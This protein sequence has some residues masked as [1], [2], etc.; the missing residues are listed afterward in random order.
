VNIKDPV[1]NDVTENVID[2]DGSISCLLPYILWSPGATAIALDGL[3]CIDDLEK[4]ISHIK[5][6]EIELP[7]ERLAILHD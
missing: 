1:Y 6:V 5:R 2:E 3:F 4:I 7:A